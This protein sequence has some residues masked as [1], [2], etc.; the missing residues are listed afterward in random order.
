MLRDDTV[1]MGL[2]D[3]GA[4]VGQILDA[5]QPTWFLS[6]WVR[7]RGLMPIERAIQRLVG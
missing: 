1:V 4:H 2:A 7:E 6:Y 5:S 3:G